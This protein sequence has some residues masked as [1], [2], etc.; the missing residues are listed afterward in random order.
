MYCML[1]LYVMLCTYIFLCATRTH[2]FK[3]FPLNTQLLDTTR[4]EGAE[5]R[6]AEAEIFSGN[7]STKIMIFTIFPIHKKIQFSFWKDQF[8]LEYLTLTIFISFSFN[9]EHFDLEHFDLD[10]INRDHIKS[11]SF[12]SWFKILIFWAKWSQD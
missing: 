12:Q 4:T 3:K 9:L 2:D 5:A 10:H 1:Q 6:S 7:F 11:W 8:D